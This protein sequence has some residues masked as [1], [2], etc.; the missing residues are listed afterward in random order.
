MDESVTAYPSVEQDISAREDFVN[1]NTPIANY[2][3]QFYFSAILLWWKKAKKTER[4]RF[5]P[6]ARVN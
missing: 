6:N 5:A 1:L 3:Q 2:S 4:G